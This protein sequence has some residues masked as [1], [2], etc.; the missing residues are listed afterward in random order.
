MKK[1]LFTIAAVLTF[2]GLSMA[3]GMGIGAAVGV[4]LPMGDFGDAFKT[5]LAGSATFYYDVM[6]DVSLTG[7]LGYA[8]YKGK[9]S[10]DVKFNDVPVIIG[11]RYYLPQEGFK[12]YGTVELGMHFLS[13]DV[14]KVVIPG[15]GTIGGGSESSSK[16]GFGVG[17][18]T[19]INVGPAVDLDANVKYHSI[20]TEGSSS[21][22]IAISVG[23]KA[24][25]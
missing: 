19:L 9:N 8:T 15:F 1:A 25:L 18:G 12:P 23:V 5:G 4:N 14:P 21:S 24:G 7:T 20:S 10:D 22:Y 3:Q 6:P 16:F 17:V 13:I 11:G 2:V